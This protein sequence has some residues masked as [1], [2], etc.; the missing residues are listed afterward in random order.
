GARPAAIAPEETSTSSVPRARASAST[1]TR[2]LTRSGSMPPAAVVRE[3][4]PTLTTTRRAAVTTSRS[5][6]GVLLGPD[7][8]RDRSVLLGS[9]DAA[10]DVRAGLSLGAVGHAGLDLTAA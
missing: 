8:V 1:S 10:G 7:L 6:I 4:D 2:P 3:E 9:V 5:V